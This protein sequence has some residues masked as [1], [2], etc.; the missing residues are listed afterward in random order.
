MA[1]EEV[2]ARRHGELTGRLITEQETEELK[3]QVPESLLPLW[4]LSLLS[5]YA[6]V[7]TTFSL[8]ADQDNSELGV[9]M[10][11]LTP[12]HMIS[13]TIET[14][15]GIAAAPAGYLPVGMCLLGSGDPYFV[16]TNAGDD[17][18]IVRIPHDA[19]DDQQKL[20]GKLIEVVCHSLSK[21]LDKATI[22]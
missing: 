5:A 1:I 8:T 7:E 13:E 4:L 22:K 16:L 10:K 6:L 11:W 9:E 15:P 12:K 14:F 20:R 21:F 17:P 18:A 19:V 2:L 3:S